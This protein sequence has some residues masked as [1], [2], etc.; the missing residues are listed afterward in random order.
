M[1][2]RI[3]LYGAVGLAL[4]VAATA[5][6]WPWVDAAA[7][8]GLLVAAGV[9]WPVQVTAFGLLLLHR[10]RPRSFLAV[11]AGGTVL[12]MA[13]IGVAAFVVTRT[14]T[15]A[16]AP[17]LLGLAGFFFGLLLLEPVFFGRGGAERWTRDGR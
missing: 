16:V 17:T 7:R 8:R 11:W 9:A 6:V 10:A 2:R 5:A 4:L 14:T 12:R 15:V 1:R 13:L 3:A